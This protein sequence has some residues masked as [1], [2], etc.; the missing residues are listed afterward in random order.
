MNQRW[1][2][3]T[4]EKICNIELKM[5]ATSVA[6]LKVKGLFGKLGVWLF[7][8]SLKLL[9]IYNKLNSP[10][11]SPEFFPSIETKHNRKVLI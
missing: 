6:A 4:K 2:T 9:Q 11:S 8:I 1:K 3:T 5:E 10:K 7:F